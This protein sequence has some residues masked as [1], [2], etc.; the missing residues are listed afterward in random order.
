MQK[1]LTT[2]I[3]LNLMIMKIRIIYPGTFVFFQKNTEEN[4]DN[5]FFIVKLQ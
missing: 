2:V 1:I 4:F 5:S 3:K